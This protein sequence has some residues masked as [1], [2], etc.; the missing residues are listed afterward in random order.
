MFFRFSRELFRLAILFS[1][2]GETDF[3][4]VF[5]SEY[6][7]CRKDASINLN[8][9]KDA[10]LYLVINSFLDRLY[11]KNKSG[12]SIIKRECCLWKN[13]DAIFWAFVQ[14]F[15]SVVHFFVC[16]ICFQKIGRFAAMILVEKSRKS[17][18]KS[19]SGKIQGFLI[20]GVLFIRMYKD[21]RMEVRFV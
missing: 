18:K 1:P 20:L 3:F 12:N 7:S 10:S 17:F 14:F 11:L 8:R 5:L 4:N 15:R 19:V 21:T 16:S 9:S 2:V 13:Y 6:T